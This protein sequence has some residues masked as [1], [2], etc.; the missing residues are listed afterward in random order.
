MPPD[1][2]ESILAAP[3]DDL[4][5]LIAADWFEENGE[6]DRAEFIRVQ[7]ERAR[8]ASSSTFS[9]SFPADDERTRLSLVAREKVL[10]HKHGERWLAP[11]RQRG[12]ALQHRGTHGQFVRGFVEVVWMP[13]AMFWR[14]GEKLFARTPARELKVTR[15]SMDDLILLTHIP[16]CQRLVSLDLSGL[17]LTQLVPYGERIWGDAFSH[18]RRLSLVNCNLGDAGAEMIRMYP[19]REPL[20]R[21]DVSRNPLSQQAIDLLVQRFGDAVLFHR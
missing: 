1:L 8:L 14:R 11:L 13:A 20:E 15:M 7:I 18:L 21:L 5:R 4:P 16:V 17:N 6:P 12:E 19:W 3:D 9:S 2:L 10:L